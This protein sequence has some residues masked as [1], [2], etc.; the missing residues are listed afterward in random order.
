MG[1]SVN[2]LGRSSR[3]EKSAAAVLQKKVLPTGVRLRFAFF[4]KVLKQ[5]NQVVYVEV[6][7]R[8]PVNILYGVQMYYTISVCF[9]MPAEISVLEIALF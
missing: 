2:S 9:E 8:G 6:P 3:Q 1:I 5:L 4:R 7:N